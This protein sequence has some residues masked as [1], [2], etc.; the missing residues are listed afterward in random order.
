MCVAFRMS[1]LPFS[2]KTSRSDGSDK[3]IDGYSNQSAGD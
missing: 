1:T 3:M 2:R